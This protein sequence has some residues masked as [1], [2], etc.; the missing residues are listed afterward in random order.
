MV[1]LSSWPR[2]R[3]L[4]ATLA[5]Y[6]GFRS[7]R[8]LAVKGALIVFLVAFCFLYGAVFALFGQSVLIVIAIPLVVLTLLVIWALPDVSNAPLGFLYCLFYVSVITEYVWPNYLAISL[9]GLPWI[10]VGRLVGYPLF[11]LAL[12]CLSISNH[13]RKTVLGAAKTSPWLTALVGAFLLVQVL[14]VIISTNKIISLNKIAVIIVDFPRL[15]I[16]LY[17]FSRPGQIR[18]FFYTLW[19]A[20]IFVGLLG[21]WQYKLHHV[22]W[23]GHIPSF[24]RINDPA[25]QEALNGTGRA[26]TNDYRINSTFV[27]S[28]GLSEF[29]AL[30]FPFVIF[31]LVNK[32]PIVVKFAALA[33]LPLM[34][35]VV[36]LT[37][38]RLGV[39]GCLLSICLYPAFIGLRRWLGDKSSLLAP[40]VSLAYPVLFAAAVCSTFFIG[41]LKAHV[42]GGAAQKASSDARTDQIH[43]GIPMIIHNPLGY[44]IGRG[45]DTLGY[46][47]Y[48][49]LTIDSYYLLV[50]LEYGVIGLTIFCGMIA[51]G[52]AKAGRLAVEPAYRDSEQGLTVPICVALISFFIIKSVFAQPDNVWLMYFMLMALAA[53]AYRNKHSPVGLVP[54]LDQSQKARAAARA[55]AV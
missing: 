31:A 32:G 30:L 15:L 48:G 17:I 4:A 46:A 36:L 26:Y 40:A 28:L 38:S 47:P 21:I 9:P 45:A 18:R 52:I 44:G 11:L 12:T 41:R 33:S 29:M 49:F 25:V 35:F 42:W 3:R 43:M 53:L 55:T 2:R 10:T 50:A 22:P 8:R 7:W 13:F 54:S 19:A 6:S 14:S 20:A 23:A 37:G 16:A 27:T 5:T 1:T 34:I 39:V 51:L 24:L